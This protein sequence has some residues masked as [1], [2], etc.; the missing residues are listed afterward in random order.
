MKKIILVGALLTYSTLWALVPGQK[1]L[2]FELKDENSTPHKL[3]Q[4]LGKVV[5]LE[6][7]NHG[8]PFVRKH[9]D[10]KN[11]QSLQEKYGSKK[12]VIWLS[13]ISSAPGKQGHSD[14]KKA[15]ADK[16]AKASKA[17]AILL[18]PTGKVGRLYG[19]KVTPHIFIIGRRGT[20]LYQGAIDNVPST[21][22]GDIPKATNYVVKA[23]NAIDKGQKVKVA[24]TTP[25][26]CGVKY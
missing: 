19:A 16:A 8:C 5:I 23:M 14:E 13:I 1:A 12:G 22:Q 6:W 21:D 17:H 7:L 18:D 9:Y 25:Y 3:S 26:G 11:M 20:V 15:R 10:S 24:K 2:D 4:Y